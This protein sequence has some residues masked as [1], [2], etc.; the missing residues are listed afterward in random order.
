MKA[1]IVALMILLVLSGCG[2]IDGSA[3]RV[4]EEFKD[5]VA[6]FGRQA[7]LRGA[8]VSKATNSINVVFDDF[9]TDTLGRC[10]KTPLGPKTITIDR[11]FWKTAYKNQRLAVV[12]HELGHCALGREHVDAV[13][14]QHRPVSLMFPSAAFPGDFFDEKSDEYFDELFQSNLVGD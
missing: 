7:L 12:F 1:R 2:K 11:R 10:T 13:D 4:D 3:H 5:A 8:D 9:D 14:D 6:I